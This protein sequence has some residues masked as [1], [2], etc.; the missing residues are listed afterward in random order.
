VPIDV[1][2]DGHNKS[3]HIAEEAFDHVQPPT[4]GGRKVYREAGMPREPSLDV[5]MFMRGVVVSNEID[6]FL[7]R[8]NGVDHA[9]EL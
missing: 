9:K 5:W 3:Y 6:R 1:I 2:A 8:D 7:L 4:A